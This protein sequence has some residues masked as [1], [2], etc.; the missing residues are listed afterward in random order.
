MSQL[1]QLKLFVRKRLTAA[2]EEI[3]SAVER[4]ILE[5]HH[6]VYSSKEEKHSELLMLA[7]GLNREGGEEFT[8]GWR[9]AVYHSVINTAY[10]RLH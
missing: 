7:G 10:T 6:G 1:Q 2:A 5:H 8:A 9:T 4:A 3:F